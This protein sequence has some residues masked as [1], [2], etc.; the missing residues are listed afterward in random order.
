MRAED[1]CKCCSCYFLSLSLSL[2]R[3][4]NQ[5]TLVWQSHFQ[6]G[7][8]IS[9]PTRER[10]IKHSVRRERKKEEEKEREKVKRKEWGMGKEKEYVWIGNTFIWIPFIWTEL[11]HSTFFLSFFSLP[12][13]ATLSFSSLRHSIEVKEEGKVNRKRGEEYTCRIVLLKWTIRGRE[14]ERLNSCVTIRRSLKGERERRESKGERRERK[15][16][17][18]RQESGDL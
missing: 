13:S 3:N 2:I 12:L 18:R 9:P 1:E 17:G 10:S 6:E 8:A 16:R 14:S 7:R 5:G 4:F 11:S 15:E